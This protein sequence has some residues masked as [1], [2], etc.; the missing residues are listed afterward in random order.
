MKKILIVAACLMLVFA[1]YLTQ[2]TIDKDTPVASAIH[3]EMKTYSGTIYVAGMG[4]H[5]AAAQVEIDPASPKPI[6]VKKL[7]RIVIG[8]SHTH[9]THDARIDVN[10][11]T[12]MYWSTYKIDQ[13]KG[14]ENRIAHVGVSDL[15]TGKV[16]MDKEVKLDDKAAWTGAL[17]C[18]SGQTKD[19]FIPLTMTNEAY[20]DVFNKKD[21]SLKHRIFLEKEG[22]KNNYFFFHGTNS[23]DMK[24]FAITIN[25]TQ[26]WAK[27]DA[28]AARVGQI[29]MLLVDLPALEQGNVKVLA[30]NTI[31][32]SPTGT[33]TF[34]Q[35][36]TP[37][38]KYLLQSGADRFYLLDGNN[39]QL[40]DEEMMANGE[41]HDAIGTP[42]SKYAVLTLRTDVPSAAEPEGKML[43]DGMLQLYDINAKRV[44]GEPTSVCFACHKTMGIPGNA[45][46]CGLDAN[47]N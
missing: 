32:G 11:N 18:G 45:V 39:M 4:G 38:G 30:K 40:L 24:T 16:L 43:K 29:D 12:K 46:L 22:Y 47:W 42:D 33:F 3:K 23:P 37:D 2:T 19:S 41:N 5:F 27:A 26:Q 20:I 28:P 31:T 36:F 1:F 15:K 6:T 35:Y 8:N 9:P 34:R 17:Y 7:D 25:K 21:L 14:L 13:E 44:I 10:D